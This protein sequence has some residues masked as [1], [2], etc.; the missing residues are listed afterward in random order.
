MFEDITKL[1][2][3]T[4][5]GVGLSILWHIIQTFQYLIWW[6]LPTMCLAG[7]TEVIGWSGHLWS[8]YTPTVTTA[9]QIQRFCG[10]RKISATLEGPTPLIAA[11]FVILGRVIHRLGPVYSRLGPRNYSMIFVACDILDLTIQGVGG[12]IASADD[13]A[14]G[15]NKI[16]GNIML[17]GIVFQLAAFRSIL[18]AVVLT[19][20]ILFA[21]EFLFKYIKDKRSASREGPTTKPSGVFPG[22]VFDGAMVVLAIYTLN[23]LHPGMLL[24]PEQ[25]NLSS[26]DK[27]VNASKT[28]FVQVQFRDPY[29][30]IYIFSPDVVDTMLRHIPVWA[31]PWRSTE[32]KPHLLD[33]AHDEKKGTSSSVP[34]TDM[35]DINLVSNEGRRPMFDVHN[36]LYTSSIPDAGQG[37]SE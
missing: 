27:A 18:L 14:A 10:A 24:G 33:H 25:S 22:L 13:E 37:G 15:A 31:K 32:W 20:Y 29:D 3:P 21:S 11:N 7:L 35:Y 4:V 17:A 23:V 19:F 5:Q 12:G 6:S 28:E 30:P 1:Q 26:S 2:L 36:D 9:F 8:A 34:L 16:G